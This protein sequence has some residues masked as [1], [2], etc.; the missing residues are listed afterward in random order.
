MKEFLYWAVG[1][2]ARIH[3]ELMHIN[4]A[5]EA[6]FTDKELHFLVVGLLGLSMVLIILPVFRA[7]A[8]GG[9]VM[10][11]TWIYVFTLIVVLTFAVEIGQK[12]SGTGN[13]EF[14]DIAS[15]ISGFLAMFVVFA[16]LRAIIVA[17]HRAIKNRK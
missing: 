13:M 7:L 17:I 10:T 5:Y 3:D 8:K 14:A 16:V 11:I 6:N 9:H 2:V 4:D 12:I 1:L 15:G